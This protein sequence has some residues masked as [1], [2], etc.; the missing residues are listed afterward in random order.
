[1]AAP[2]PIRPISE[3]ELPA[4]SAVH[5]H[6]FHGEE[7]SDQVRERMR[8]RIE[9][10]RT[11]A[12][13]DGVAMV[14]TAGA[15]SFRMRVP[16][17]LTAVAGVSLVAVLPSHRRRGILSSLMRRQLDDVH[18][19]GEAVAALFASESSI[20]GRFGYGRAAWN[21]AHSL[22]G[23]E[24][25]L[26]AGAPTDERLRLRIAEPESAQADLARVYDQ[27]LTERPGFTERD[28][29]WWDRALADLPEAREGASPLRCV[30]AVDSAG[31][32]G[33]ALY[34]TRERWDDAAFLPDGSIE[35]REA[36][37]A[38]P[39]ATAAI[40]ADLLGR[41]L[42][43]EFHAGLRPIDDPLL[44][45]LADPRRTRTRISDGLWVRLVDVGRALAQRRYTCPVDV[46]MEV[47]DEFC[48]WNQGRWRLS[49][50]AGPDA[51]AAVCERTSAPADVVLPAHALGAAFLGGIRL[52]SMAAAGL[53]TQ[54]RPGALAALSA[55]LSWDVAP[56]CPMIF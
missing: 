16:G 38:D 11:L 6:A 26:A 53:V 15:Y 49:T 14:G 30:L 12:A 45:L 25:A 54:R 55:A 52:G 17:A 35:V 33:Y 13:F 21:A 9:Y 44:H 43:T 20:Y 23:G 18:E 50:G 39:A 46:V 24:G 19:G 8:A 34:S 31:P 27:V 4:L 3:D 56:W 28:S 32:R 42:T 40:W 2:Y 51:G 5:A 41:D 48:P 29:L 22:R 36:I 47:S 37:A 7:P 1:M 10:D